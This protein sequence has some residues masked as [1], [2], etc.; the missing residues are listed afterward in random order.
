[1]LKYSA[2]LWI[3]NAFEIAIKFEE[4]GKFKVDAQQP[5]VGCIADMQKM[6]GRL[7]LWAG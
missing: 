4:L 3:H 7:W 2:I 6:G 5:L 1:L